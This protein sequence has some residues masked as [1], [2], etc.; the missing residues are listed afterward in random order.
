M[1]IAKLLKLDHAYLMDLCTCTVFFFT[2]RFGSEFVRPEITYIVNMHVHMH[3]G[4]KS[5]I[6]DVDI[7][8]VI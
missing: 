5:Y 3:L 8:S 1:L 7:E 4:E 6:D 2:V